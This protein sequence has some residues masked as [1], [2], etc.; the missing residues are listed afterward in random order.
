M[1]DI[2][3][4]PTFKIIEAL[5]KKLRNLEKRRVIFLFYLNK[6]NFY[7]ITKNKYLLFLNYQFISIKKF[8]LIFYYFSLNFN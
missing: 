8:N 4:N 1:C 6:K 2:L 7:I 5:E 3:A